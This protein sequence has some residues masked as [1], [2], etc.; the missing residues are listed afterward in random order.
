MG[1]VI[2]RITNKFLGG[3]SGDQSED[4]EDIHAS[5][6]DWDDCYDSQVAPLS[7]P[8]TNLLYLFNIPPSPINPSYAC[9][10]T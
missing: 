5:R 1:A 8:Y 7:C 10:S 3:N 2:E 9:K 6:N 4:D